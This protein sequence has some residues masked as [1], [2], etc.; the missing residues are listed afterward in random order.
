MGS[1][2]WVRC[3]WCPYWV[4][5]PYLV[6]QYPVPLCDWCSSIYADDGC[7][8]MDRVRAALRATSR[9]HW[10]SKDWVVDVMLELI[11]AENDL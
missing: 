10:V 8:A 3:Y 7:P 1:M 11:V 6:D 4:Y 9:S 2:G 5:N